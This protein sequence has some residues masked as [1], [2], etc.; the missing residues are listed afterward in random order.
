SFV[1]Y[2]SAPGYPTHDVAFI[3]MLVAGLSSILMNMN[4][5]V[6][7]DG[8]FAL[9]DYLEVSNLSDNASKYLSALA[10]KYIFRTQ[11]KIPDY[12][13]RMKRILFIYGTLAICYRIFIL[14][15]VLLLFYRM[16]TGWFPEAGFFI[17]LLVA[18]LLLKKK[19]RALW[20]GVYH[21]YVDK[22]EALM[23]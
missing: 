16:I 13:P 2:F 3:F 22:K 6:K 17:F 8:Y 9:I 15:A 21:L 5:L 14:T 7:L 11:A 12:K 4:P 18:Y 20:N 19:L 10:R 1:W 23:R